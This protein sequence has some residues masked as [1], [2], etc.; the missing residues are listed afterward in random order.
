MTYYSD[1]YIKQV[2]YCMHKRSTEERSS[3]LFAVE[4]L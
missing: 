4:K 2:R 3:D 1:K